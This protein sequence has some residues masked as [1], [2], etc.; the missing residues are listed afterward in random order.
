MW[1]LMCVT[2]IIALFFYYYLVGTSR[3]KKV[4]EIPG[5]KGIFIVGNA[6]DFLMKAECIFYYFR[7]LANKYKDTFELTVGNQR[8]LILMHPM[9]VETLIN[10]TEHNDKG[11]LYAF[12]RP[13]LQDGLLLSSETAMGT[14]LDEES[15]TVSKSYKTAIHDLG[16]HLLYRSTRVWLH[17]ESLFNLSQIGRAQKKTLDLITSFR[18]CVIDQR[19][20][21]VNFK[22]LYTKTMNENDDEFFVNDKRRLAMLDILLNAEQQGVMDSEG[23]NEEV[24]TFMFEG[25]DTTATALQF[26]FM[27]LANHPDDQDKIVEEYSKLF[28]SSN[29][30]LTLND[31]SKMKYLEACI[32]ES[33]RLY[34]PVYFIERKSNKPLKLRNIETTS[35]TKF[36]IMIFD[37]HRRSDQFI[38][39][40]E[41]RPERFL[42]EPTWHPFAYLPFSA[43]KRNCIGQK[44]AMMEMKL[45]ISA[46]LSKYRLLPVTKPQDIVFTVDI[47][48]RTRDPIFVKFEKR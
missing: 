19:R 47:V 2:I 37:L 1:T 12:L 44:F 17:P 18:N 7:Y 14:V 33:L 45:A 13:W 27:L 24:D 23:I 15:S 6:F 11:Y 35:H 20:Q 21:N 48:L 32:K 26:A 9:H 3:H 16:T 42:K 43:G 40:L 30:R 8:F 41:F 46:V 28:G 31:L 36:T 39:P 25:H 22:D 5:P 4:N 10:S 38:E 34:P 29:Q